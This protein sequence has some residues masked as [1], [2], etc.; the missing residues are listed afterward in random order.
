M[1]EKVLCVRK[2]TV[3]DFTIVYKYPCSPFP[4]T[5]KEY[6]FFLH[7]LTYWASNVFITNNGKHK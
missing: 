4:M 6:I 2:W 5:Q 1:E 3:V 7:L